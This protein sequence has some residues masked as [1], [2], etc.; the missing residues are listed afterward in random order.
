MV[1]AA[2]N[3]RTGG[4]RAAGRILRIEEEECVAGGKDLYV[5]V[6][7]VEVLEEERQQIKERID[8]DK[9]ALAR[10][11]QELQKM[12]EDQKEM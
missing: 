4:R 6:L 2:V 5:L 3:A 7:M 9:E 10:M 8:E 11:K 12:E 1:G